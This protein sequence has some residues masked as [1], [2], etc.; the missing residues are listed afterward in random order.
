MHNDKMSIISLLFWQKSVQK[1]DFRREP[2]DS[3]G[4][5]AKNLEG[6]KGVTMKK[7]VGDKIRQFAKEKKI[8]LL[9]L[10]KKIKVTERQL[11]NWLNGQV[12][13]AERFMALCDIL[14]VDPKLFFEKEVDIEEKF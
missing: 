2:I 7:F 14:E 1:T 9:T 13:S 11:H 5:N 12:P 10:S 3:C 8:P 4:K 6:N